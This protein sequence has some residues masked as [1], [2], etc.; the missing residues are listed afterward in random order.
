MKRLLSG[1]MFLLLIV[2]MAAFAQDKKD[3]DKD[4]DKDKEK[5]THEAVLKNILSTVTKATE[6]LSKVKDADSAKA[7]KPEVEKINTEMLDL[8]VRSQKLGKP[9]DEQTKALEKN[10]GDKLR[11]AVKDLTEQADR[12]AKET[13][14]KDLV[15]ILK[16][17]QK[18]PDD[19]GNPTTPKTAKKQ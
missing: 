16:R 12:L 19:T 7:A 14:G 17:D 15:E 2:A 10:Y 9:T 11:S 4:K 18:K 1:G 5:D 6:A 8:Q 3:T 13:Y